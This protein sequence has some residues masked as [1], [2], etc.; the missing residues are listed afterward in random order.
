MCFFKE[1]LNKNKN[2]GLTLVELVITIALLAI[3]GTF[4]VS[5]YS[6]TFEEKRMES[7]M[8]KMNSIDTTLNQI[9]LEDEIFD[10]IN[11]LFKNDYDAGS[12]IFNNGA[13]RLRFKLDMNSTTEDSSIVLSTSTG[14]CNVYVVKNSG[15][16]QKMS[17]C[18]PKTY[19]YL[20]ER[21]GDSIDLESKSYKQGYYTVTV[22]FNY[23]QLTNVRKPTLA[24]DS[25]NITNSGD[26]N[27]QGKFGD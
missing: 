20:V 16:V 9:I 6:N 3:V 15:S 2:A 7:D 18:L 19:N 27:I 10:E 11:A 5:S 12:L 14:A 26:A 22:D 4:L 1:R 8:V 13:L 17:E 24:D 23:T 21:V 25:F